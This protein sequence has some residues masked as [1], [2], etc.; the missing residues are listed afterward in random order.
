VPRSAVKSAPSRASPLIV[1]G[2]TLRG[3][4]TM[5]KLLLTRRRP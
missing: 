1:G 4:R 5:M 3:T 2:E